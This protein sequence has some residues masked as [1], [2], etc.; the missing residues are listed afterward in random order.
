MAARSASLSAC[1]S[2][3]AGVKSPAS[4]VRAFL[5]RVGRS[6]RRRLQQVHDRRGIQAELA[7]EGERLRGRLGEVGEPVVEDQLSPVPFPAG[8]SPRAALANGCRLAPARMTRD[9]ARGSTGVKDGP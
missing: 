5:H 7:G 8:P 3:N 1:L 2:A 6:E 9:L 4:M